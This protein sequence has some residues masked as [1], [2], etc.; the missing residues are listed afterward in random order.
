MS[1]GHDCRGCLESDCEGDCSSEVQDLEPIEDMDW[2]DV[3]V[4]VE[5]NFTRDSKFI[6]MSDGVLAVVEVRG[7]EFVIKDGALLVL[8]DEGILEVAFPDG[9]WTGV[10]R[11]DRKTQHV[12]KEIQHVCE[13][14][15]VRSVENEIHDQFHV[16]CLLEN[17]MLFRDSCED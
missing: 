10:I 6:P 11:R 15:R 8:D 5:K 9:V 3:Y 13:E 16:H 17:P 12:D 2:W 7:S 14:C 4:K 1:D